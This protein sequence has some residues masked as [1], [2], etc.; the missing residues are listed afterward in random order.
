V[1]R[2][3]RAHRDVRSLSQTLRAA[4]RTGTLQRGRDSTDAVTL[5]MGTA[6]KVETVDIDRNWFSERDSTE[7]GRAL[8]EAY[9]AAATGMLASAVAEMKSSTEQGRF[10][11]D[12]DDPEPRSSES[13]PSRLG[14]ASPITFDD[15]FEALLTRK[16]RAYER[17]TPPQDPPEEK[18]VHGPHRY[19]TITLQRGTIARIDVKG[20]LGRSHVATLEQ[21]A[22]AAF[23]R[24]MTADPLTR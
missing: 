10:T 18:L 2:L 8:L 17:T 14:D 15:V 1:D 13:A 9:Q 11:A 3:I 12:S 6:G 23:R 16:Q 20:H 7:L 4:T 21:D 19:V 24:A 5:T 22:A